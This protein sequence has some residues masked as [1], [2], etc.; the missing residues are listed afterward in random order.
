MYSAVYNLK[1]YAGMWRELR[2]ALSNFSRHLPIPLMSNA[3]SC[4]ASL[5][6]Q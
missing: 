4:I 6:Y 2:V 1:L 3:K 5:S